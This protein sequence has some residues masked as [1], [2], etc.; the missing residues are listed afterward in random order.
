MLA[1]SVCLHIVFAC[2]VCS[3]G[4]LDRNLHAV[5]CF[6]CC[7]LHVNLKCINPIAALSDCMKECFV[8]EGG[9]FNGGE[10]LPKVSPMGGASTDKC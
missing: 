3:V 9:L 4:L 5:L 2:I 7:W 10:Y 1:L 6:G 8:V